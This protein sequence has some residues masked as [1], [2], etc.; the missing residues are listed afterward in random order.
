MQSERAV[1]SLEHVR[2]YAGQTLTVN[3][4][5]LVQQGLL[6]NR[7]DLGRKI[8]EMGIINLTVKRSTTLVMM[9]LLEV[10]RSLSKDLPEY[11]KV[12]ASLAL[13]A[14]ATVDDT[15]LHADMIVGIN[16]EEYAE[17]V[18]SFVVTDLDKMM[19]PLVDFDT[20]RF[21][22]NDLA[23]LFSGVS[24]SI[25]RAMAEVSDDRARAA[26]LVTAARMYRMLEPE[27]RAFIRRK[28]HER[29]G[30]GENKSFS[31]NSDDP[32]DDLIGKLNK[33]GIE[34]PRAEELA[35]KMLE[36]GPTTADFA[37]AVNADKVDVAKGEELVSRLL[38]K[39]KKD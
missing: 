16:P 30:D 10:L 14:N 15:G 19:G 12:L 4:E 22:T 34:G 38:E 29:Q 20:D 6:P 23:T 28:V 2:P 5:E 13:L 24:A 37:A 26:M 21:G 27:H 1:N 39:F 17:F 18:N 35:K 33:M 11:D 7:G 9:L 25:W 32:P 36:T 3:G 8:R 31:V